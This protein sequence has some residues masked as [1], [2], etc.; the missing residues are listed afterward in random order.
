MTS[1][2]SPN[3]QNEEFWRD[4]LT[5]GDSRVRRMRAIFR[6]IS[7]EPRCNMCAA[8]FSGIGAPLMQ[9]IDKRPSHQ[10]P[11]MCGSC[12]AGLDAT[13]ERRELELRGHEGH[14]QVV[15]L[16]VGAPQS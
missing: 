16:D 7:S 9:M 2:E 13:L 11:R 8:P 6:R 10:T 15:S 12:F 4:F 3:R 5:N 1:N 14:T